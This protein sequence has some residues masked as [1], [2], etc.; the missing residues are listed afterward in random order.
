MKKNI[1]L[2]ILFFVSLWVL[3]TV[4]FIEFNT[5]EHMTAVGMK[6]L[7][8][9]SPVKSHL[10][11]IPISASFKQ[12]DYIITSTTDFLNMRMKCFDIRPD[13]KES[14]EVKRILSFMDKCSLTY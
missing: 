4:V 3:Y 9:Q 10:F 12:G 1:T 2:L 5:Q 11:G 13:L 6:A 14:E 8:T 7:S